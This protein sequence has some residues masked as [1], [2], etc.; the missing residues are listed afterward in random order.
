MQ[1]IDDRVDRDAKK[2]ARIALPA[3]SSLIDCKCDARSIQSQHAPGI[4]SDRFR[5]RTD[6]QTRALLHAQGEPGTMGQGIQHGRRG[7]GQQRADQQWCEIAAAQGRP[8][9]LRGRE[10]KA[11]TRQASD[12]RMGRRDR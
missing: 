12:Q 11:G 10:P 2:R 6:T 1:S 8:R 5:A 9:E 3:A 7:D 4:G